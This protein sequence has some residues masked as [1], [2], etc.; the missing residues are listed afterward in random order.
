[1]KVTLYSIFQS[2]FVLCVVLQGIIAAEEPKPENKDIAVSSENKANVE[3]PEAKKEKKKTKKAKLGG[4]G[5]GVAKEQTKKNEDASEKDHLLSHTEDGGEDLKTEDNE[6]TGKD[7]DD[8]VEEEK[9]E[10]EQKE[11]SEMT[12]KDKD[13]AQEESEDEFAILDQGA[14]AS[15]G[16]CCS[17]EPTATD[18][19]IQEL[20]EESESEELESYFLS[21][22]FRKPIMY[23]HIVIYFIPRQILHFLTARLIPFSALTGIYYGCRSV[24]KVTT[25]ETHIMVR[26]ALWLHGRDRVRAVLFRRM[27]GGDL[28]VHFVHEIRKWLGSI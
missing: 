14:C 22:L 27:D 16:S 24:L 19:R 11:I 12:I 25:P 7:K 17:K 4:K 18:V 26:R 8:T 21:V 3:A 20:L 5:R 10:K 2:T 28:P 23:F 6:E 9:P 1:M 13:S 15:E